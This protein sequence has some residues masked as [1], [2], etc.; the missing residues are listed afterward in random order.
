MKKTLFTLLISSLIFIYSCGN[1]D[2]SPSIVASF[3]ATEGEGN[4]D[5]GTVSIEVVLSDESSENIE[6]PFTLGGSASLN[7]DYRVSSSP[8]IVPAGSTTASIELSIVDDEVIESIAIQGQEL[9]E[10]TSKDVVVTLSSE[11]GNV[12]ID[13]VADTFTYSIIDEDFVTVTGMKCDLVWSVQ[14]TND[15]DQ[16]NLDMFAI[17]DVVI[18]DGVVTDL[19]AYEDDEGTKSSGFETLEIATTAPDAEYYVFFQYTSGSGN[20]EWEFFG[21]T[22]PESLIIAEG[23]FQEADRDFSIIIGPIATKTGDEFARK[24][25]PLRIPYQV[26]TVAEGLLD[27]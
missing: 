24:G 10:V 7:G 11:D 17:Y 27:N 13:E 14:G 15:S 21:Y 18:E 5:V 4:E 8:L 19:T 3:Q 23:D 22:T 25:S 16:I 1:D 9:V 26:V 6:I 12:S 20:A 2:G